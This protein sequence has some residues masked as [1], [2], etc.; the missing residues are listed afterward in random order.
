MERSKDWIDE[1]EGDLS[2]LKVIWS[3]NFTT[4][5]VFQLNNPQ[6]KL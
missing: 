5:L 1:A 3:M 2:M 6:K 4:G